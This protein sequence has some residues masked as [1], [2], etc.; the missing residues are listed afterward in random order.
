MKART[1]TAPAQWASALVNGDYSGLSVEETTRVLYWREHELAFGDDVV[2]TEGE[3]FF[4]NA[5]LIGPGD[6]FAG[7]V[8]EYLILGANQ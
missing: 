6:W 8:V 2:G 5:T 3:E 1:V 7:T 4:S